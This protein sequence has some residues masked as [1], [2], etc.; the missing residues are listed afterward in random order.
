MPDL[1][2]PAG[3]SEEEDVGRWPDRRACVTASDDAPIL[4]QPQFC[5]DGSVLALQVTASWGCHE[6]ARSKYILLTEKSGDGRLVWEGMPMGRVPKRLK[7]RAG[8][9]ES[10]SPDFDQPNIIVRGV[11]RGS[12]EPRI[13]TLF[14]VN[15]EVGLDELP[16]T[17]WL[18]QPEL[19]IEA[20]GG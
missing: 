17:E 19:E 13:V 10:F 7:L 18:F 5:V 4:I 15:T 20:V 8:N 1:L 3:S 2:G 16:D 9:L 6:C 11:A 14:L 12:N